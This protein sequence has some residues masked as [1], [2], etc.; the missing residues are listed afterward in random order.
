MDKD[1]D[2]R[3]YD[4][5]YKGHGEECSPAGEVLGGEVAVDAHGSEHSCGDEKCLVDGRERVD[6]EDGE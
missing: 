2:Q 4:K 1:V 3:G 5:S 6:H